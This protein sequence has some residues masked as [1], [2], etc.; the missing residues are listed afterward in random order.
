[1][2]MT[3]RERVRV[4]LSGGRPDRVP[5]AL[6]FFT[7]E[8]FG[9]P[10]ADELF[11]TDVRFVEF[12]PPP[13]QT[14]FVSYLESLPQ[15]TYV[16]NSGQLRSYHEWG[17][18]PETGA[19][20]ALAGVRSAGELVEGILPDLT[21]R[22]R[23]AGVAAR[24]RELQRRGLAVAA[25]PPHLGGELFEA[26]YRLRGFA[27]F[28]EDLLERP[29]LVD[30]L[31][32]QLTA[33]L[34]QNATILAEAGVDVLLLD[35]DVSAC[36]GMLMSPATWRR[37]FKPRL[38]RVIRTAREAAPDIK[39]FYHSDGDFSRIV[40]DLLD[41][42]VDVLNPLQPDCMD[43]RKIRAASGERPAFWGTVGSALTWDL[44]SPGQIRDEVA[45][46]LITL[47]PAGLL[48]AP[49]YDIDFSPR[50]NVAAFVETVRSFG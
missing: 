38:A 36:G 40:P 1:M 3:S 8:L 24:V 10:D 26:A 19:E 29:A 13:G 27:R 7:Q 39:I 2:T 50:E 35:D 49:A 42:G 44:G 15:D 33:M 43:A 22:T 18:H 34:L 20:H 17:Y 4:A 6:G 30:F 28:M 14:G 48:L 16:G 11:Q 9:S 31:L 23:S 12:A 45:E 37:F 41:A 5:C 21:D 46:R 25:P 32:D 47:G